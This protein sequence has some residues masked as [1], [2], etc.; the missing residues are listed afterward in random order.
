VNI[1]APVASLVQ[2]HVLLVNLCRKL[3]IF[4]AQRIRAAASLFARTSLFKA[5]KFCL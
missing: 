1:L 3:N 2:K 5:T 4:C